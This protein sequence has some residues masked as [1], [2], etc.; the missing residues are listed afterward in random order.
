[1]LNH[2]VKR[3]KLKY[4]IQWVDSSTYKNCWESEN[5]LRNVS[6]IIKNYEK[7]RNKYKSAKRKFKKQIIN[8]KRERS[9]KFTA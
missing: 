8:K 5:N 3:D 1:M 6:K 2:R 4:L 7:K 9:R